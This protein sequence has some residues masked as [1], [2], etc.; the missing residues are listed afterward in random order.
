MWYLTWFFSYQEPIPGACSYKVRPTALSGNHC[1]AN[2]GDSFPNRS[3]THGTEISILFRRSCM[4]GCHLLLK[5]NMAAIIEN[6]Q[7]YRWQFHP[8][9]NNTLRR[10]ITMAHRYHEFSFLHDFLYKPVAGPG[11][12]PAL[13]LDQTEARRA[14]KIFLGGRPDPTLLHPPSQ[15]LDPALWT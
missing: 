11:E 2:G 4:H 10:K 14:R 13:F 8:S 9:L 3:L 12:G 7:V 15:G 6:N 1:A 5:T